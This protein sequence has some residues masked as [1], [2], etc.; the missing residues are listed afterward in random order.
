MDKNPATDENDLQKL[1]SRVEEL[2]SACDRLKDENR[3]LR[4]Q[5]ESLVTE[6]AKLI[7]KTE[8]A[9]SRV[10]SMILRLKAMEQE[11]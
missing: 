8:L 7:E 6:R 4:T 2:I 11:G 3:S 1:E 5:Q 10:E 9:R